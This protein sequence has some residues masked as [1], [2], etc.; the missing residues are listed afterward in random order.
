MFHIL[1]QYLIQHK[2]LSLPGL[3]TLELQNI[4][5]I[6]NFSDH[7]IEPPMQ[8]IIFDDMHDA[9]DKDLFQ[10]VAAR[11]H[12][13]EWEAIKR[14]NDFSYELKNQLKEEGEKVWDK[15]G[16]LRAEL[17]GSITLEAKTITYDFMEP[18]PA[19]RIIRT[20]ANHTILRGDTEVSENFIRHQAGHDAI[21]PADEKNSFRQRWWMWACVLGGIVLL[22]LFLHLYKSGFTL[23][24][25]HNTQ[26]VTV[27]EA[28]A[29]YRQEK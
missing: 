16:V 15:V 13:E 21:Y 12:I 9:P 1:H 11:L 25:L 27:K 29:T 20:N 23:N 17:G 22:L 14:V 18:V 24:S 26:K 6:S 3:G 10:Y 28:P 2:S 5:A 8:K 4:P 7:M 19:V